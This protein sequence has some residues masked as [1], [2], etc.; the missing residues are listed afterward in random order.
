MAAAGLRRGASVQ[1][2]LMGI[3]GAALVAR[4]MSGYCPLKATLLEGPGSSFGSRALGHR[5]AAD[6]PV[7]APM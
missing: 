7:V 6:R 3:G 1:G 4:G 2:A 5:Q